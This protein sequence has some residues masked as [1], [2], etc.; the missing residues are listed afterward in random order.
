M[1]LPAFSGVLWAAV[2]RPVGVRAAVAVGVVWLLR[3]AV[4]ATTRNPIP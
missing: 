3:S 2:A 4:A 1:V